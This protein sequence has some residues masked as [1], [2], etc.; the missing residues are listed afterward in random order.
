MR[1]RFCSRKGRKNE[2][3]HTNIPDI[4]H[5]GGR[6]KPR[7]RGAI[8]SVK[9]FKHVHLSI[10]NWSM[11]KEAVCHFTANLP[12]GCWIR[13][14]RLTYTHTRTLY[15]PCTH[16]ILYIYTQQPVASAAAAAIIFSQ[17][18]WT[19]HRRSVGTYSYIPDIIHL[20]CTIY[21]TP[22]GANGPSRRSRARQDRLRG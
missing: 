21:Y 13:R 1:F 19:L 6:R 14:R 3:T 15:T 20:P 8:K 11:A 18:T 9:I 17:Q 12:I 22:R 4:K 2:R 7:W 16:N 10:R 5:C